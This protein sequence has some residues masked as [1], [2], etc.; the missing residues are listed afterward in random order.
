MAHMTIRYLILAAVIG[1]FAN[2]RAQSIDELVRQ[3]VANNPDLQNREI[4]IAADKY[5]AADANS[6][7][8][9]EVELARVWGRDGIGNKLQLDVSQGFDWP[10]AYRARS[11]ANALGEAAALQQ[12]VADRLDVAVEAKQSLV[13]LV[14]LRK[15]QRLLADML[16]GMRQLEGAMSSSLEKGNVTI[17]DEK[18]TKFETYKLESD[19]AAIN[20]RELE[21]RATLQALAGGCSLSLDGVGE[22]PIERLAGLDEY[23]DMAMKMDPAVAAA[24]MAAEHS[25]LSAKAARLERFP[26]F[27]VGYQHQAEMGD[28]FNG[29]TV[30]MTL[31]FF[32]KRKSAKAEF[33][34][35]DA[36][37]KTMEQAVANN[38]ADIEAQYSSLSI[39]KERIDRYRALFGDKSYLSLL[40]KAFDGGE[41]S[42]IDYIIESNYYLENSMEYLEMEYDYYVALCRLNKY[43]MLEHIN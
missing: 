16:S 28:R 3:I 20:M 30:G 4:S 27:S 43:N 34:R 21:V 7:A 31:P 39:L 25:E 22:Y 19:L 33:L 18:K 41:V 15:Q 6:L 24:T 8:N 13:E 9:P 10:G 35:R 32:E 38:N 29:F 37:E 2:V 40:K 14:Y 26:S 23:K 36:A 11:K 5:E 12:F 42:V 17:L 1:V